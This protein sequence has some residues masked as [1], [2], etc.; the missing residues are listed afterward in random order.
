MTQE[1]F[2]SQQVAELNSAIGKYRATGD[3]PCG[4]CFYLDPEES[5]PFRIADDNFSESFY[6][7]EELLLAARCW[8]EAF[9]ED[10]E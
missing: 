1:S 9:D 4:V 3:N 6:D 5:K 7:Y 8:R 2:T 10:S